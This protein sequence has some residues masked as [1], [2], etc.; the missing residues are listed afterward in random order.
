[1]HHENQGEDESAEALHFVSPLDEK[2]EKRHQEGAEGESLVDVIDG[3]AV[4]QDALFHNRDEMEDRSQTE[5][6]QGDA[7]EMLAAPNQHEDGV[8]QTEGIQ[9]RRN[10]QPDDAHRSHK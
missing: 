8:Q 10:P 3:A 5:G 2:K 9:S 4:A 6:A 1:R 7:I